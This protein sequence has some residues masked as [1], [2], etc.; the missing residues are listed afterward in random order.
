MHNAIEHYSV[1]SSG[2]LYYPVCP[3]R[4]RYHFKKGAPLKT[5]LEQSPGWVEDSERKYTV[6]YLIAVLFKTLQESGHLGAYSIRTNESIR[7]ALKTKTIFV[8]FSR[9]RALVLQQLKHNEHF[10][11]H[12][13]YEKPFWCL[14]EYRGLVSTFT[15]QMHPSFIN[16]T[17]FHCC[18]RY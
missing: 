7:Q 9:V 16:N 14:N 12:D 8:S 3:H 2:I 1:G 17:Y 6:N 11:G 10:I 5:F 4:N 18:D 15:R 13:C